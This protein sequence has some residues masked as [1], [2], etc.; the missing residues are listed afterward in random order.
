M[1]AFEY[2][3]VMVT[4]VL[5]LAVARLLTFLATVIANPE[6]VQVYWLHLLWTVL[7]LVLNLQAW[8]ILWRL[9]G[10]SEFPIGQIVMMVLAAS[11]IFVAAHVLVPEIRH[12]E[13]VDLRAYYLRIRIPLFATLT[14]F[15]FFPLVGGLVFMGSSLFDPTIVARAAMLG[16][17][18]SGLLVERLRW[19][20]L[21][22]TL[23]GVLIIGSLVL[24]RRAVA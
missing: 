8:L 24:L 21:L 2:V 20:A 4:V 9:H 6:R 11:L 22:A 1:S 12:D 19:H 18:L 10:Q 5:A 15:W 17:S 7:L 23:S 13:R 14:T 16:L 3:S